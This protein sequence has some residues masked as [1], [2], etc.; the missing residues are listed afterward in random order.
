M[1]LKHIS[2]LLI[3]LLFL[4]C[5]GK[6]QFPEPV[7]Q[8]VANENLTINS[9]VFIKSPQKTDTV[10]TIISEELTRQLVQMKYMYERKEVGFDLAEM[11]NFWEYINGREGY[12]TSIGIRNWMIATGFLLEITGKEKYAAALE[13]IQYVPEYNLE[14]GMPVEIKSLLESYVFTR[15][16][17]FFHVNLFANATVQFEHSLHGNVEITQETDFPQTGK[18]NLKF[19]SDDKRY[20]EIFVRIPEWAEGTTV[21]VKGVKYIAPPGDYCQ[22]AKRWR[23]GDLVEITFPIEKLP[24]YFQQK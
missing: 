3:P 12:F 23:E 22:I 16:N 6:K 20:M 8:K 7:S 15:N 18:V 9:P 17:D 2:L 21:T 13:K 1:T 4:A 24:A 19:K 14:D 11:E 10:K 5:S